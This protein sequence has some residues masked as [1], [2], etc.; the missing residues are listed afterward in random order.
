MH[1][2]HLS[3][4]CEFTKNLR[5]PLPMPT[6]SVCN[7]VFST[8]PSLELANMAKRQPSGRW[9]TRLGLAHSGF[10][11]SA[12]ARPQDLLRES[13][14]GNLEYHPALPLPSQDRVP[15]EQARMR[16]W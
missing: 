6:R 4:S 1:E 13:A 3:R 16:N 10:H 14:E 5:F 2:Q 9:M 12:E 15:L 11:R 8:Q 7:G